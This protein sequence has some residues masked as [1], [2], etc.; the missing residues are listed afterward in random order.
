[1]SKDDLP[2]TA[3]LLVALLLASGLTAESGI[4][5][6]DGIYTVGTDDP[7]AAA[8]LSGDPAFS[9]FLTGHA[10]LAQRPGAYDLVI[11][12]GRALG[13]PDREGCGGALCIRRRVP[14][15][16]CRDQTGAAHLFTAYPVRGSRRYTRQTASGEL[17]PTRV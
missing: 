10:V 16:P 14:E 7:A 13:S 4:R 3:V 15:L 11:S 2:M 6:Q 12:G 17:L 8:L 5:L 1:M 9:V